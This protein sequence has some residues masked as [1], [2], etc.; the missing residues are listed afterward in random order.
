MKYYIIAGEASGDLH[1]ANL[2]EAITKGDP[3]AEFRV[4]GGDKM[5]AAGATLVKHYRELAFM[6]FAEVIAN[7]RT[8]LRNLQFCKE[9]ILEYAP[10]ALILID[11]PGFNLRVAP[12]ADKHGIKCYYYILPQIWAWKKSRVKLLEKHFRSLYSILPF[13][14]EFYK[15]FDVDLNYV[16]HPL[17]DEIHKFLRPESEQSDKKMMLLLPGS[18]LQ[19]VSRILPIMLEAAATKREYEIVIAKASSLDTSVYEAFLDKYPEVE[20][21]SVGTYNLLSRASMALVTSGTATLETALF[22]V[23]QVVCYR[24]SFVS[25]QIAKRI[26]DIPYISLVNL[27]ADKEV[28][29]ELIQSDLTKS[30]LLGEIE[31]L[32]NEENRAKMISQYE[33][34]IADLGHS[35]ASEKT[36]NLLLKTLQESE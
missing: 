31:K 22:K 2:I 17:L 35:G 11:Y 5:E 33:K 13:E 14:E 27:I 28:V 3:S 12:F 26:V 30:A 24:G 10:D 7:L 4:W 18:R 6:G 32:E 21:S 20:L 9:D 23:P 19:E 15:D 36:A 25:F 8:I 1:G 34:I 29:K 16:G